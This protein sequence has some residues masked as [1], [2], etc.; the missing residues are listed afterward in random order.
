MP[1][2]RSEEIVTIEVLDDKGVAKTEIA[3]T[4]GVTE[5]TVRYH[6]KRRAK[7]AVDGRRWPFKAAKHAGVI[8]EWFRDPKDGG[9]KERDEVNVVA[10]YEQLALEYAYE[11]S[12]RS[13]LR[14]VKAK[15]PGAKI[16]AYR[17]VETPEGAQAQADWVEFD[18]VDLGEGPQKLY[19]FVLT[20][21]HSRKEVVIWC[22]RMEQ[23][24]WH[25][26]HNEAL[27]RLEGVPAVIRIDNLKTGIASGAGPTGEINPAYAA[28]A[29][30][31][32]FH[33]DACQAY[34]PEQKGK[35]ERRGGVLRQRIDPTVRSFKDL[36]ELQEWT[37]QRLQEQARRRI[38]PATGKTVQESWER[39]KAFLQ[40]LP[41]LPSVF[42]LAVRRPVHKDCTVNFESRTYSVPFRLVEEEVEVRGCAET[43]QI[44]HEG[45][46][47]AEHRRHTEALLVLD[48]RHYEG[49]GDE[50]VAAPTPLGRMGQRLQEI[51]QLPVQQRPIDLYAALAGVA[52]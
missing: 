33:V 40:P 19:A 27:K 12:Y 23:I 32:R 47:V 13:L 29:K 41:I 5:G 15:Y 48:P 11:G 30:A 42:D 6:L 9:T 34:K 2:L 22:R 25:H 17:R 8:E 28:Y 7:E 24:S 10:L 44:V 4:L 20:L 52:R 50:R 51:L 39:E 38:C 18:G 16:R 1:V 45:E 36:E 21:S 26:A 14:Y 37:D 3:R 46:V 35:V 31:L 43:V 49:A